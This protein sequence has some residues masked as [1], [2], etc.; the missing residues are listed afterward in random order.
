MPTFDLTTEPW[1]PVIRVDG[2]R[3]EVSLRTVLKE[4]HTIR[5]IYAGSPLQTIALY[6]LLQALILRIDGLAPL[7]LLE[8]VD[9][10]TGGSGFEESAI[11]SYFAEWQDK[12]E[13]FDLIHPDRPFYQH[14]E[15]MTKKET[16]I[17]KLFAARASGN[18][19]T[20]FDHA[21]DDQKEGVPLSEAARGVVATQS[22][23]LGGGRSKPFYYSDAPFVAGALFWI[24]GDSLF[25]SLLLNTPPS[26]DTRMKPGGAPT[27]ERVWKDGQLPEPEAR[28]ENGYLDYLTWPARRVLLLT[29]TGKSGEA[30][31]V[32]IKISQG[33]KRD[34]GE[35]DPVMAFKHSSR[36]G[37]YPMKLDKDRALWRDANVVMSVFDMDAGGGPRTLQWV[38]NHL[39]RTRWWLD[40]FGLVN[41]QAKIER[42]EHAQMPVYKQIIESETLQNRLTG[43]LQR[44]EQQKNNLQEAARECVAHLLEFGKGYGG[45]S[46][47][48]RQDARELARS[49]GV[50]DRY[51]S[52]LEEPFMLWLEQLSQTADPEIA[53]AE[54][55]RQLYREARSAYDAATG[56]LG[57]SARHHRARA[58]GRDKLRPTAAYS[59]ILEEQSA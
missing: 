23:A 9:L 17:T 20:L 38:G 5:E 37:I 41:D 50:V 4:A 25:H 15:P 18:N 59:A 57:D 27:W 19:A 10:Y 54:W 7:D 12:K 33:D 16:P 58:A 42:W 39:E 36:S 1:I 13:C 11:E 43:A 46:N 48:G 56:S 6:R 53:I 32:A 45:L 21:V 47:Q 29:E 30:H 49:I 35:N 34:G 51:W 14:T 8:W 31:A 40:V 28:A 2:M 44:S 24:R 52:A 55:T 22:L 3:E 26:P